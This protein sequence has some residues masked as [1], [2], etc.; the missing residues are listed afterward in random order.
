MALAYPLVPADPYRMRGLVYNCR[1]YHL[2]V[3]FLNW[4]QIEYMKASYDAAAIEILGGLDPV[5]KRP[6]M[7]TDTSAP[8]HLAQEVIDNSVDEA[9][10]G[11]AKLIEVT[12]HDDGSMSVRDDGRGMPV[13]RHPQRKCSGVE[14]IFTTLHSGGKFSDRYYRYAGGLHG[15]GVSVVN[16]LSKHLEVWTRRGGKEYN[17]AFTGGEAKGGLEVVGKVAKSSSGSTIRFWP[18]AAFFEAPRFDTRRLRRL[19]VAKAVLCPGL[20]VVFRDEKEELVEEWV[21]QDG[22]EEYFGK[23]VGDRGLAMGATIT[24]R[25]AG[26]DYELAWCIGW[27]NEAAPPIAESYVN[28]VPTPQGGSHVAGLRA[29]VVD[30]VREFMQFH[31][32]VPRNI[33]IAPDDI[34]SD[35]HYLLSLKIENPQFAG[36]IKER[37]NDR[38]AFVA[39]QGV[40]RDALSLW[41]NGHPKEGERIV[42]QTI[43]NA[44]RRRRKD[45]KLPR[46][47]MFLNL[48]LP[49]K[50]ADCTSSDLVENELFLVEGDSAGGSARQARD[51]RFQ[52]VMPLRG[53]ILNTW[54]IDTPELQASREVHD[55]TLAVGVK[56]GSSDLQGLRYGKICILADADADGLHISVLLAALFIKHFPELVIAGHIYVAAPPLYRIDIDKRIHYAS[57]EDARDAYLSTLTEPDRSRARITHFKGLGEM[58]PQQLKESTMQVGSRSLLQLTHEPRDGM[59]GVM[60]VLLSKKRAFDRREW[61]IKRGRL[62]PELL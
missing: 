30:A 56:P 7:Y 6:G 8:D 1:L 47:S 53:K 59:E 49:G 16:A 46:K 57:D 5:R 35:V 24:D 25:H 40:V 43:E 14:V 12:V 41:L 28:L 27:G 2:P 10:A 60:D 15:V 58:N 26:D 37:L 4:S 39:V 51:R 19:L 62:M 11:Y 38:K 31:E 13:D 22:L 17:M 18:D 23:L 54:E 9:L 21:Y 29:G 50:L 61:L 42:E 20:R 44:R 32:L 55:I 52:A 3:F 45:V 36:Q 34:W 48:A 33:K